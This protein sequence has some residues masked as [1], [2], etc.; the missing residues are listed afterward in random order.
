[1]TRTRETSWQPPR[2]RVRVLTPVLIGAMI[3]AGCTTRDDVHFNRYAPANGDATLLESADDC[4]DGA[5]WL[6]R[7]LDARLEHGVY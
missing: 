5:E 3:S 2:F 7:D 6:V 4:V 1:M